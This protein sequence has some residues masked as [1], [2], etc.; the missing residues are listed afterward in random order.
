LTGRAALAAQEEK[1]NRITTDE[2]SV[3]TEA[4]KRDDADYIKRTS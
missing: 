4:E 1:K 3:A 2:R